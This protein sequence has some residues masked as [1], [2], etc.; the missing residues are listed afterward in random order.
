MPDLSQLALQP[1][2]MRGLRHQSETGELVAIKIVESQKNN[3]YV[4]VAISKRGAYLLHKTKSFEKPRLFN[5]L[6][7]A[8]DNCRL[9]N[10]PAF[11]VFLNGKDSET[12]ISS[13]SDLL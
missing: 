2:N 8:A 9:L 11:S 10:I 3:R 5:S 7:S 6:D 1:I 4:V 12:R 13:L